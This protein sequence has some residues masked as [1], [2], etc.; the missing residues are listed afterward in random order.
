MTC[1]QHFCSESQYCCWPIL[2]NRSARLMWYQP[3]G[4]SLRPSG[5]LTAPLDRFLDSQRSVPYASPSLNEVILKIKSILLSPGGAV[6]AGGVGWI[7]RGQYYASKY[8]AFR[9]VRK[10][11]AT[12]SLMIFLYCYIP[13]IFTGGQ[14]VE[15]RRVPINDVKTAD[16]MEQGCNPSECDV[17]ME[18]GI[19]SG[20]VYPTFIAGLSERF[21]LRS[22]GGASVGAIAAVAAAAA[23]FHRNASRGAP[24]END[25]SDPFAELA[26]LGD[27]LLENSS[28]KT[29]LFKLFQPCSGLKR[30]FSTFVAALNAPSGFRALLR[31]SMA[32][33]L[34]FAAGWVLA[35]LTVVLVSRLMEVS[36][37]MVAFSALMGVIAWFLG[38]L[39][40]FLW[41][42]WRGLRDNRFGVCSGIR[43]AA[44]QPP[45]LTDWLYVYVQDLAGLPHDQPLTFRQLKESN[46]PIELVLMTTGVS[47]LSAH[48]LPYKTDDLAFRRSDLIH[49][50]PGPV[51]DW[52][53]AHQAPHDRGDKYLNALDPNVG[54]PAQDVFFM[55]TGDDL[56]VVVAARMSLSFP[57][58]MQAIPLLRIRHYEGRTK[59]DDGP[60]MKTVWF[61]DGGLTNNFP[62]HLFD[63]LLPSRPTFGVVLSNTLRRNGDLD[64]DRV[65]LAENNSKPSLSYAPIGDASTGPEVFMFFHA[66]I[67]AIRTWRHEALRRT[68][69]FR[70][71]VVVIKHTESEGGLNL[72]MPPEAIKRMSASGAEA[73]KRIVG[74]FQ[75]PDRAKNG[76]LNH[77]FVR[78]R[79]TAS[80]LH[81]TLLPVAKEINA[82]DIPAYTELWTASGEEQLKAYKLNQEQQAEGVEFFRR[83]VHAARAAKVGRFND[84][85]G[86]SPMP[87][88]TIAPRE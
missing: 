51:I 8:V 56:P 88:L 78:M 22:I 55:P 58:L 35:A 76:W 26:R 77:R 30:H 36:P 57:V 18:G 14:C 15:L 64:E 23:Q 68:P 1:I 71:R 85:N 50:F 87:T 69:G 19:T 66:M 44:A 72:N 20:I 29:N 6:R 2:S 60:G 54:T 28:G 31:F 27:W 39:V 4:S 70:D 82:G 73:A 61:S 65:E 79:T 53:V 25:A 63:Q 5:P 46:K 67:S 37:G 13:C 7:R 83:L 74:R 41:S 43:S 45:A 62:I 3:S 32:M 47:E 17:V 10:I 52:M 81:N 34:N 42:G 16:P 86:P 9:R 21:Q 49:L 33:M 48:Q 84:D 24:A 12:G 11:I 59:Q 75:N 38:S 80:L 40:H